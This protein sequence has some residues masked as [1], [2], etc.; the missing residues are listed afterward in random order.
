MALPATLRRHLLPAP[1]QRYWFPQRETMDPA[2][3]DEAIVARMP[4]GDAVCLRHAPFY[5]RKWDAAG[6]GPD[7]VRSLADFEHVPVVTKDEI[8]ASQ[9]AAPPFGDYLC[10]PE[11]EVHHIHGTS[12]TSG[13]PTV[14]GISR[15]DWETIANNHARIMW[16]MGLRPGDTV[17]VAAIL[18]LYMGSWGALIGAERLGCKAFPFGAGAPGMTS[19]AVTWLRMMQP[20]GFY[21]TPPTPC[22]SRRWPRRRVSIRGSSASG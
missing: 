20:A 12:G 2:E 14:F 9:T 6:I 1:D 22:A 21:S 5:R 10:V 19:R 17:F 13:R 3:R 16:G 8:R 15:E 7:D 4:R 11:E 18:S